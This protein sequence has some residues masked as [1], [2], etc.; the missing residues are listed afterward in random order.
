MALMPVELCYATVASPVAAPSARRA[1]R[2]RAVVRCAASAPAPM[3]EKTEYR[4]GPLER[5]FMG[6]FARKMEKFA[7]RKK[8]PGPGG[9]EEKKAVW[10]WDYESF[11]DVSRRVMV[12]RSR[13]QQQEAVREVLLSM[14][15]PGA[16]EQ[17]KKLFPPTRWAC[18]F[19]AALTVPFFHWLV[20][21]SEVIEVEVDGV[22]QRSGVLIKKCRYLENS[23]CVGMCVN[24]CKIPT[25]SF[26]TDEFGLPLTM[27][28][29]FED[30]S[31]EMIYGQVPPPLEEDPVS[32]QPCYPSLCSI[33][34][35]SAAICPKIQN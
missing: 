26:F 24:M 13:A 21:P 19:N 23:G 20:G 1:P 30:M 22:K 16:P 7:G 4:D 8:K 6:L 35:P 32:K 14:L 12:G 25:Q 3:G 27:N 29:N 11:V 5:A 31:C 9:E 18:E 17:F 28:P 10:E 15:P 33:S 34:T 2:R